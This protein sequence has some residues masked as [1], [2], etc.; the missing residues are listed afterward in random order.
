MFDEHF[1]TYVISF[2]GCGIHDQKRARL[3]RMSEAA[4]RGAR[5][6]RGMR[7]EVSVGLWVQL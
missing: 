2:G 6:G 1:W 4:P 3:F 5:Y 7:Q